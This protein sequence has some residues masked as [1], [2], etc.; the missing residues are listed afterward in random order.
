MLKRI[1]LKT[2]QNLLNS[3]ENTLSFAFKGKI[4]NLSLK[5]CNLSLNLFSEHIHCSLNLFNSWRKS[6]SFE[7]SWCLV[8]IEII[9]SVRHYLPKNYYRN[10]RNLTPNPSSLIV[11]AV[12]QLHDYIHRDDHTQIDDQI[13]HT[14]EKKA[15]CW[16]FFNY[17]ITSNHSTR[18]I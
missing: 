11:P 7:N 17:K 16:C 8:A 6:L 15:G 14:N 2:L 9:T 1:Y 10:T 4:L 18:I 12:G 3:C 13:L 5:S